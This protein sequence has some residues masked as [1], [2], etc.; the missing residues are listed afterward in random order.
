MPA[1]VGMRLNEQWQIGAVQSFFSKFGTW[2]HRPIDF[3]AALCDPN[4]FVK[5]ETEIEFLN[6]DG[7][8]VGKET[9][10]RKGISRLPGYVR[11]TR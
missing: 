9:N 5:F 6:C 3:P 1:P 11:V 7:I 8:K 10:V 2:F 4:G